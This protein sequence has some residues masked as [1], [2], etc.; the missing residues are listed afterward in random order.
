MF[1]TN[2][3]RKVRE[4]FNKC[5]GTYLIIIVFLILG[6]AVGSIM[7]KVLEEQQ[8]KNLVS[9]LNSYFKVLNETDIKSIILLKQSILNN[10]KTVFLLWLFGIII[11][12]VPLTFC[13]ISLRGFVIGF[14][15]SFL[16]K[17]FGLNGILFSLLAILPQN[18]FIIPGL[19]IIS[20]ISFSF[21]TNFLKRR[22]QY[23][24]STYQNI[25]NYSIT[26]LLVTTLLIVG[27][28][29]EAYVTPVFMK[30]VLSR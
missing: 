9:F 18:I 23:R 16:F 11:I 27:S 25:I 19:I 5:T 26:I 13:I 3:K 6:I 24:Y 2:L 12:G 28:I 20:V 30:M 15:V 29:V 14:T 1:K 7:S 17:E 10:L 8:I 4:H 22:R 21:S